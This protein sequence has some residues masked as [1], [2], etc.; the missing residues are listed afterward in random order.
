MIIKPGFFQ[1]KLR[2]L[3][4][5]VFNRLENNNNAVFETNGEKHFIDNLF[6]YLNK[7]VQGKKILFDVGAN[8]GTYSLMLL[9]QNREIENVEIHVFEPTTACFKLLQDRFAHTVNVI[10]N[11]KAVSDSVGSAEIYFDEQKSSLASLY[12]RN[13]SAYSTHMDQSE[14]VETIRLEN[15]F[16]DHQIGHVHFLKIDIE[17]HEMAAFTGMGNYLNSEFVDFIQFE[18]GGA[19]L[20]SHTSLME[21]YALLETAGF[22]ITKIMP[23]GLEVRPYHPWMD[24]FQYANYV[25]VSSTILTSL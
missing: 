10:L 8:I 2:S 14:I 25:A 13:L 3:T 19:N 9:N 16:A 12:K 4:L 23:R 24:N 5:T 15:Y 11:K 21:L 6:G 20:D 18:Y 7:T 1:K 22:V 17:G